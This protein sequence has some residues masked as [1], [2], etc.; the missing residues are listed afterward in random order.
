MNYAIGDIHGEYNKLVTLL[1][2]ITP[3]AEDTIY[4]LGDTIDRGPESMKVLFKLMELPNAVFIAGNHEMM[5]LQCLKYL[6]Q[7]IT[8]ENI[9]SFDTEKIGKL[10][11]WMINGGTETMK[12][13]R[14]LSAEDRQ[15][16]MDFLMEF[17]TCAEVEAGGKRYILVHGCL[18]NFSPERPIWEYD[19]NEL[20]WH[21]AEYDKC[22]FKDRYLVTGHTPTQSIEDNPKPG[23]IYRKNNHIAIDCGACFEG[24]RLAAICLETGEEFYAE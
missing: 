9:D 2:K 19:L 3:D 4:V 5:A 23:Y 14:A 8:E 22:Y 13:F 16:V 24:G 1:E 20:I 18:D 12:S 15:D 6:N 21:R 17:D 7:E 10:T 11:D